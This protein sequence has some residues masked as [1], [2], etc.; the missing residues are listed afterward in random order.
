MFSGNSIQYFALYI[1]LNFVD[2]VENLVNAVD[3]YIYA[4]TVSVKKNTKMSF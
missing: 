2:S 4:V 1:P 3:A